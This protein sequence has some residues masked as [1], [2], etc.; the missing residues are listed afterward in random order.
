MGEQDPAT[1]ELVTLIAFQHLHL[2]RVAVRTARRE[3]KPLADRPETQQADAELA[4]NVAGALALEGAL[5]RVADMGGDV[6]EVGHALRV[7][8]D[9]LAIVHDT[10]VVLALLAAADDG[11]VTGVRVDGVLDELGD[12]LQRAVL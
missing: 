11:D 7:Q 4:L 8:P 9:A 10:Q 3:H 2:V 1:G 12:C 5:D 6:V